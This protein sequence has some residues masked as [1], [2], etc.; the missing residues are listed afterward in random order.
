MTQKARNL[1]VLKSNGISVPRGF[2]LKDEH[3]RAA[4]APIAEK[5]IS[6]LP[7][8]DRIFEII[9]KAGMSSRTESCLREA[10]STLSG[11]E[12][13]A[14]RSSGSIRG[15]REMIREDSATVSLAGQFDSFLNVPRKLIP[16]A[17]LMCWSSLFNER[18]VACFAPD[19]DYVTESFMSVVIQE[20][21]PARASAVMMTVDPQGNGDTGAIEFT[22][23][24]CEA[25]VS[26]FVNPDEITFDRRSCD[27]S[28]PVLGSKRWLVYYSDF[29]SGK[30]NSHK[31][32]I[33]REDRDRVS[34]DPKTLRE[35]AALGL[36]VERLF[37]CPQDME[38]VVTP[39]G[40]VV[41]TQTRAITTLPS[42]VM[43]LELVQ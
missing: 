8:S 7:S 22:W 29:V 39:D 24:P 17:V 15:H 11:V 19:R 38:I 1:E 16:Q 33:P 37:G 3:Y 40:N 34:L 14:V 35:I 5:I 2:A 28:T 26:G 42:I 12:R 9:S 30:N 10:L 41:V 32:P 21:I 4:I 36:R 6:A 23:G 25:L 27:F 20:M 31:V 43:P 13:F 18:S